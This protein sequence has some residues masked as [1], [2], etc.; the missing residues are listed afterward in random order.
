M[1]TVR[2]AFCSGRRPRRLGRDHAQ[3]AETAATTGDTEQLHRASGQPRHQRYRSPSAHFVPVR[4]IFMVIG[5]TTTAFL[6]SYEG[7]I[8]QSSPKF[9]T[10]GGAAETKFPIVGNFPASTLERQVRSCPAGREMCHAPVTGWGV[11]EWCRINTVTP[12]LS[13]PSR[14]S[15]ICLSD[16]PLAGCLDL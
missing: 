14:R 6:S 16:L 3:A 13:T 7:L 10:L 4:G 5:A 1:R 11:T 8:P 15:S 2:L 9:P 12:S